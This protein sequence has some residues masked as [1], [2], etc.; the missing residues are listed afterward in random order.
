[1]SKEKKNKCWMTFALF[2][3]SSDHTNQRHAA[4]QPLHL[5]IECVPKIKGNYSQCLG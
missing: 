3:L 5:N 4:P 1:M 2:D